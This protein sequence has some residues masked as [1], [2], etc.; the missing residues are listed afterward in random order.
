MTQREYL[1]F[2]TLVSLIKREQ[3]LRRLM[4]ER[5]DPLQKAIGAQNQSA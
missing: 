2:V 4:R 1:S 3:V 5:E